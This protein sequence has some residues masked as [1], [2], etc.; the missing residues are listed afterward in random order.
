M[1]YI[2]IW[3]NIS[4]NIMILISSPKQKRDIMKS[5]D[6]LSAP[7]SSLHPSLCLSPFVRL[8]YW[9]CVLSAPAINQPHPHTLLS[10]DRHTHT[11]THT[12]SCSTHSPTANWHVESVHLSSFSTETNLE[13]C[14]CVFV[15]WVGN[16]IKGGPPSCLSK[17]SQPLSTLHEAARKA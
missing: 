9:T 3:E 2:S 6:T 8:Y 4:I 7:S 11:H 10:M 15:M 12:H 1:Q 16:W 5:S 14:V 17:T 13:V